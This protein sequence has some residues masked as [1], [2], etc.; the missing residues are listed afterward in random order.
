MKERLFCSKIHKTEIDYKEAYTFFMTHISPQD[1]SNAR[2][3]YD[4][5]FLLDGGIVDTVL[6]GIDIW[7]RNS[8]HYYSTGAVNA[9]YFGKVLYAAQ[10]S[11]QHSNERLVKVGSR[12]G[13]S[14]R[15]ERTLNAMFIAANNFSLN[16]NYEDDSLLPVNHTLTWKGKL[17]TP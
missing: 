6:K 13:A 8:N 17:S 12:L 14:N 15:K 3:S 4:Y 2:Q 5:K 11:T 1:V 9:R 16:N 7:D 10:P